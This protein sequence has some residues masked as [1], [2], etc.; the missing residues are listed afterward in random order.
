MVRA[1]SSEGEVIG[2]NI[3]GFRS[4]GESNAW[5]EANS[6]IETFRFMVDVYVVMEHV[7]QKITGTDALSSLGRVY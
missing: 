7:H 5:L 3:L 4:E 2:L 6:P 1:G